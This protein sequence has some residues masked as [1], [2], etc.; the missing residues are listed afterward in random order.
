MSN[1]LKYLSGLPVGPITD[2]KGFV[3]VLADEWDELEGS[4]SEN[5]SADKLWRMEQ[6]HWDGQELSF[7][8]ERHGRTVNGSTR[9]DLHDWSVDP[10]LHIAR[11]GTGGYRQKSP[12]DQNLDVSELAAEICDLIVAGRRDDNRIEFRADGAVVVAI[13]KVIAKTNKWTTAERRKRFRDDLT[14]RLRDKG[15]NG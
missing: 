3:Q 2:V 6:P 15:W 5:T 7:S 4:D 11:I 1:L 10:N 8:L 12:R 14:A 9:A 13:G